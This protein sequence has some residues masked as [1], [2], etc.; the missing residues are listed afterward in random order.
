MKK[1][2]YIL[3]LT[4]LAGPALA[5]HEIRAY[6]SDMSAKSPARYTCRLLLQDSNIKVDTAPFT[7]EETELI[8]LSNQRLVRCINHTE[9]SYT[10]LNEKNFSNYST[11]ITSFMKY[12]ESCMN[13]EDVATRKDKVAVRVV[14]EKGSAQKIDGVLCKKYLVWS[15]GRKIQEIW[16]ANWTEVS[17]SSA[18]FQPFRQLINFYNQIAPTLEMFPSPIRGPRVATGGILG[19]NGYPVLVRQFG[20]GRL[21]YEIRLGLPKER[22]VSAGEF[23]VPQGYAKTALII[24]GR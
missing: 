10:E 22:N 9:E 12:A 11:A 4:M 15:D 17:L 16:L 18:E 24:P 6:L 2:F 13:N 14:E 5:G 3:L 23:L 8:Y 1:I 20:Q 7:G 21:Q 19:C